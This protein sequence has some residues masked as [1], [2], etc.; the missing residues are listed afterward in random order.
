MCSGSLLFNFQAM[1]GGALPLKSFIK[2]SKLLACIVRTARKKQIG[3]L[4]GDPFLGS[5]ASVVLSQLCTELLWYPQKMSYC[6]P[7]S[8]QGLVSV[9]GS[10]SCDFKI[11]APVSHKAELVHHNQVS[12]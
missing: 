5:I 8:L 3:I 11:T 1:P 7:K 12:I 2:V 10:F 9:L 4:G 6:C